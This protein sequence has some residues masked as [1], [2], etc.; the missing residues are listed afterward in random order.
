MK[1]YPS[2]TNHYN[3][4]DIK[5]LKECSEYDEL[6]DGVRWVVQEKIHGAN[7]SIKFN[8]DG[9]TQYFSRNNDITGENFYN[10]KDVID[11]TIKSLHSILVEAVETNTNYI[12]FGELFGGNIQKGVNYGNDKRI[13][14]FDC[15]VEE[16]TS[17]FMSPSN[18]DGFAEQHKIQ[19]V[20]LIGIYNDFE[21]AMEVNTEFNSY[22]TPKDHEG[23]NMCEG[24]VIKPYHVTLY[25]PLGQ[26]F[27]IK[28]K[29][30]K[31]KEKQRVKQPVKIN[32][33]VERWKG[34]FEAYV[35]EERLQSVMSK[36]GDITDEN[37]I[38]SYI[39]YVVNDAK[40]T[41]LKEEPEFDETKFDK[42]EL[43]SIYNVG[44]LVYN[45]ILNH[46]KE[47]C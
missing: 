1:K 47:K 40:E 28:K 5:R 39:G 15:F 24:V 17:Y 10:A 36:F 26:L 35:N 16:N 8:C 19:T 13:L 25:T 45:L 14:F 11:D 30:E 32:S 7:F 42:K 44:G 12:I 23:D 18:F 3:A 21:T 46:W 29:N 31:F 20:P 4:K 43:K 2:L 27:Y 9:T 38:K 6:K 37:Q 34:E 22:L 33:E 41:F